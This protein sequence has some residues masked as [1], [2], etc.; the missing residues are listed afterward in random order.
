MSVRAVLN[1]RPG[2]LGSNF[3]SIRLPPKS[4]SALPVIITKP[5]WLCRNLYNYELGFVVLFLLL[6]LGFFFLM[7]F[8]LF[9]GFVCLW[10]G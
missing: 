1:K 5:E 7:G 2:F 10:V 8:L 3:F 6:V 9:W 4:L